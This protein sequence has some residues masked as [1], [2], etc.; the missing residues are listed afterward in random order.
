MKEKYSKKMDEICQKISDF[1][2]KDG[3]GEFSLALVV[4]MFIGAFFA[5]N[6]ETSHQANVINQN[7]QSYLVYLQ[8]KNDKIDS[9]TLKVSN[10]TGRE[11]YY[12]KK[13]ESS[14]KAKIVK[15]AN[16]NISFLPQEQIPD[17]FFETV[18]EWKDKPVTIK[19]EWKKT[20][21]VYRGEL[22]SGGDITLY[23][24]YEDEEIIDEGQ[25]EKTF[26]NSK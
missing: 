23:N 19:V 14:I 9:V 13:D 24:S 1:L 3:I 11:V 20:R 10:K 5:L 25:F 26:S 15:F 17:S 8:L 21:K 12:T 6:I 18:S 22:I 4:V 7:P 2:D 16:R